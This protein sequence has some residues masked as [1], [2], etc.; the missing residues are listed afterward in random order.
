MDYRFLF[1]AYRAIFLFYFLKR[2]Q[3]KIKL[4]ETK[5]FKYASSVSSALP[6]LFTDPISAMQENLEL[7]SKAA[8]HIGGIPNLIQI[9]VQSGS[10]SSGP[11]DASLFTFCET[12][13][14]LDSASIGSNTLSDGAANLRKPISVDRKV[15]I[16]T[17]LPHIVICVVYKLDLL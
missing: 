7:F 5:I 13:S 2:L 12:P 14:K 11:L 16:I 8:S 9:P 10:V 6:F 17:F 3:H 15:G 1:L 4:I